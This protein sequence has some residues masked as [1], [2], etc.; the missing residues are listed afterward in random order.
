MAP[1]N[2]SRYRTLFN[3]VI[4]PEKMNVDLIPNND[5]LVVTFDGEDVFFHDVDSICSKIGERKIKVLRFNDYGF[6]KRIN[7]KLL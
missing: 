6:A 3:S 7:E 4:I 1:I 2:S 5:D